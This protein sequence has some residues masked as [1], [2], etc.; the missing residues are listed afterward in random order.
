MYNSKLIAL[1]K[2]KLVF[3]NRMAPKTVFHN[4]KTKSIAC[5][6]ILKKNIISE[7]KSFDKTKYSNFG[8]KPMMLKINPIILQ[9]SK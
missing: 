8:I 9:T 7:K 4:I 6:L 5:I 3:T 1:K 2:I